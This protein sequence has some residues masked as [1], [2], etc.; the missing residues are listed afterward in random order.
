MVY[1]IH[2]QLGLWKSFV[3]G[4]VTLV[5]YLYYELSNSNLTSV[6]WTFPSTLDVEAIFSTN[7]VLNEQ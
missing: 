7:Y 4:D 5:T 6:E 3:F 2:S 1:N